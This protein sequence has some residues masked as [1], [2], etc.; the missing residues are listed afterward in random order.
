SGGDDAEPRDDV[1]ERLRGLRVTV[2]S[3]ELEPYF[4]EG[5]ARGLLVLEA[6]ESWA[7]IR[8]GDVIVRVDGAPATEESLRE[9]MESRR[10]TEV[11]LL[12]RRRSII[13]SLNGGP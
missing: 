4:G 12:R 1:P 3:E 6:D 8:T 13:V 11:E 2:V 9:A 7:P 5:S 10:S